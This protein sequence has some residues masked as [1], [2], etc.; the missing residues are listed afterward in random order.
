VK[1]PGDSDGSKAAVVYCG[2][3]NAGHAYDRLLAWCTTPNLN[4][5]SRT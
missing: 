3:N 4:Q 5:V 2:K 1:K